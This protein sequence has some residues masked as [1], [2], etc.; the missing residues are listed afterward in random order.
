MRSPEQKMIR[1]EGICI[2]DISGDV[3]CWSVVQERFNLI[4]VGSEGVMS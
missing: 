1:C 3:S 4:Q 2:V